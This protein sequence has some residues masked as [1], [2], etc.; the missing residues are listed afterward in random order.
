MCWSSAPA[1][2]ASPPACSRGWPNS[3]SCRHYYILEVSADL[4]VRQSETLEGLPA[5]LRSRI[6]WLDALPAT[7]ITGVV[8]ANEVADA[9]PFQRFVIDA[10]ALY[11]RGVALSDDAALVD[12]D[13]PA[14]AA[15]RRLRD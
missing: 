10:E 7:P 9:L 15:L 13:R 5:A 8:L 3:S 11:Q 2:A 6:A 4:R 1:P 12:A 14:S